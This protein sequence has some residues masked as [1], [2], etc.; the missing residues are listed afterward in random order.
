MA[1][2]VELGLLPPDTVIPTGNK[3]K[4][5]V[6][7]MQMADNSNVKK[8]A[9][10]P[11][12][13][14]RTIEEQ[15]Q[16]E[17]D[18]A[19]AAE[20]LLSMVTS[21]SHQMKSV[22]A[23]DRTTENTRI[24]LTTTTTHAI[25]AS[26]I[27]TE[28]TTNKKAKVVEVPTNEHESDDDDDEEDDDDDDD[29]DDG[30]PSLPMDPE[31]TLDVHHPLPM[32]RKDSPLPTTV[33]WDPYNMNGRIVGWRVKINYKNSTWIDGRVM[34]Y[35][36]YTH[37]HKVQYWTRTTENFGEDD[38]EGDNNTKRKKYTWIWLRNE[39]H[40]LQL[41]T[42]MVW[43]HV[44]GYAWWPALVMESN[45]KSN[46][47]KE[48]YVSIEFFGTNEISCLR[49]TLESIRPFDPYS[50]DPVVA[51]HRKKRNERAF[52]L[53]AKEYVIIQS[54]RNNAA[55]YYAQ[56]AMSMASY[57]APKNSNPQ[58]ITGNNGTALIGKR[59]QLFRP[60][61]NY[62]YGDTVIGK[63][64]Q[65]SFNQKKWLLSFEISEKQSN[66][67]KYTPAWINVYGKEHAL[68]ILDKNAITSNEDMIPFLVGYDLTAQ[69]NDDDEV[70]VG[71]KKFR[72]E[73]HVE[74]AD[75]LSTRCRGC[76]EYLKMVTT[77]TA[78]TSSPSAVTK[79][80]TVEQ[81]VKC[82]V[83]KGSFHLHCCDPP[84]LM[85]QW[86]RMTK[87][88]IQYICPKCTPCRGC[89][90]KDIAFGSYA[91]PNP[92]TSLSLNQSGEALI[93]CSTCRH[94]YDAERFCPNCAHIWDD[95]KFRLVCR[96]M[97]YGSGTNGR[98]KKG[99][100]KEIVL[101]DF[102]A[103]ITFGNFD[104]DESLPF[105]DDK[106]HPSY[107]YPETTEWGFTED[108]MLVCDSCNFW[109]HAGCSGMTEEEYEITSNGDHPIY[110]KEYFCRVCCR[111]RCIELIEALCDVDRKSLFASPVSDRIV[112]NYYD[113]IKE[114]MDLQTMHEKAEKDEYLNYAWVREMFELMVLNALTFNRYVRL[115]G[116]ML[117]N[118]FLSI[119]TLTT[120]FL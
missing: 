28:P 65:Y 16:Q 96:Q 11:R 72:K 43:A 27:V 71:V 63:V 39:Q 53:A 78:S 95:K 75:L 23:I 62:P 13:K 59:I 31:T 38:M 57:Y 113:I 33:H 66:R 85:D 26:S 107:F 76:V 104:G 17:S 19:D 1:I 8:S 41:A 67:T 111:K 101:E 44:K 3:K 32:D 50:V 87:E 7:T 109:V 5:R 42:R 34:R 25:M 47:T 82:T 74:I 102:D 52:Q 83:C 86:H 88:G 48:G 106:L 9:G 119:P 40:K 37:K 70:D 20:A 80:S 77:T 54:T 30:P 45:S 56:A 12:K 61:V 21:S 69:L 55:I 6:P 84:I 92:P 14:N 10:R 15:Q 118:Y 105:P 98:R 114:P 68:K 79:S 97:D 58:T 46:K 35:D 24:D 2:S 112:P 81:A 110:S 94:H 108:E 4:K 116:V 103:D 51:K 100:V 99:H 29:D 64:R 120:Y 93:L 91:H 115:L 73:D 49:D 90:Q 60:D 22:S 89:Y 18:S 117:F 36:P